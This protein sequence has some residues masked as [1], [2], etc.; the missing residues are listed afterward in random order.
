MLVED[1][2]ALVVA[3]DVVAVQAVAVL[4]EIVFAFGPGHLLDR[5]DGLA[6][7]DR[8]GGAGLVDRRGEDGDR[9]VGPRT[10]VVGGDLVGIAIGLA[11]RLRA[12]AGILGIVGDAVGPVQ[13]R[14]G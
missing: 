7:L 4:V 2:I 13:R 12:G 11:E 6:H 9:I 10:L 3:H 8:I 5:Q 1:D 14:T